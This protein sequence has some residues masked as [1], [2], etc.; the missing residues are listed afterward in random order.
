MFRISEKTRITE[1]AMGKKGCKIIFP[2]LE[3]IIALALISAWMFG[4][5]K[6]PLAKG[7][8]EEAPLITKEQLQAMLGN[9]ELII[10]DVRVDREWEESKAKIQGAIREDPGKGIESWANKYP[11]DKTLVLYCS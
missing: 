4:C 3:T 6:M 8:N 2:K 11:K 9:P 10:L 5:A 7:K 1:N